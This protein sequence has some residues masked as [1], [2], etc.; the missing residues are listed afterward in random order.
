MRICGELYLL[1]TLIVCSSP[2]YGQGERDP[3]PAIASALA[4]K[5]FDEAMRLLQPALKRFP[6][7]PKLWTLQGLAFSGKGDTKDALIAYQKA[8]KLSPEFLP[9]LEGAAQLEYD[10]G[11]QN[12][13]PYLNHVLRLR[14]D[15]PTS[16]TMLAV[17]AYKRGNCEQAAEHFAMSGHLMD[18]QLGV[19]EE[20]SSCLLKLKQPDKAIAMYQKALE[21]NPD[22]SEAR[23]TL[24]TIQLMTAQSKEALETLSPLLQKNNPDARTLQLA[25]TAYE[26]QKN[27][28]LA[29][30]TL[31]QAI[32]TDPHN[33]DLYLDF[34][35]LSMDHQSYEVGVDMVNVGLKAEPKSAPLYVA[36]GVLYVQLARY[37]DAEDDF[38]KAEALEPGQGVSSAAQGLEQ[39]QNNNLDRALTTVQ[40]K[41]ANKPNDPYLLYLQADILTQMGL[42]PGSQQFQTAIRSAKRAVALQPNLVAA[43]DV[44]A[45]LYL[46]AGQ[47]Q[48]ASE[49]CRT[50][51]KLDPKDQT[52]LYHLIQAQRKTGNKNEIPDLLKRLAE[53]RAEETKDERERNRYKLTVA[54]TSSNAAHSTPD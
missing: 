44:L 46:Q 5:Q 30:T 1:G 15:D 10:A 18:S 4:Q 47:N 49:H 52:A 51:L 23:H 22:D 20:Y 25:S 40:A 7:N 17:L 26:E 19:R 29:V 31:R 2:L 12:A 42:E 6:Q 14:P 27:T 21:L 8:L 28:P 54:G 33:V 38:E 32:V 37:D 3:T 24:A 50:A 35:I 16:H 48:A 43:H 36:R 11:S 13:I 45:K 9:A 53:L 41:L 39:A 34:A